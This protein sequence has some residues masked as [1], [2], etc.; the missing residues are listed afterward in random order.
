[1]KRHF[2][3]LTVLIA[4]ALGAISPAA[5]QENSTASTPADSDVQVST[6]TIELH[7]TVTLERMELENG[8]LTLTIRSKVP[9]RMTLTDSGQMVEA[10]KNSDGGLHAVSVQQRTVN[11]D[12]GKNVVEFRPVEVSGV[13]AVSLTV[14]GQTTFIHSGNLETIRPAI[15]WGTVQTLLGGTALVAGGGTFV[16]VRRKMNKRNEEVERIV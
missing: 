12:R 14:N 3:I 6:S 10:L 5:A 8:T 11:L 2:L 7:P 15:A 1:M 16:Y 9:A 13:V 4:A